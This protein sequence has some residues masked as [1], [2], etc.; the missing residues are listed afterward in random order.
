MRFRAAPTAASSTLLASLIFCTQASAATMT[1]WTN[2]AP[3]AGKI[4]KVEVEPCT[5]EPC[6]FTVGTEVKLTM[7]FIPNTDAAELQFHRQIKIGNTWFDYPTDS[8]QA[9]AGAI[10][11]PL[12]KGKNSTFTDHLIISEQLPRGATENKLTL[13]DKKTNH[14]IAC[15]QITFVRL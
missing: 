5:R 7:T 3:G 14:P 8:E 6:E 2:C 13:T 1:Q 11:C 12:H 10:A 9:C 4:T 15:L